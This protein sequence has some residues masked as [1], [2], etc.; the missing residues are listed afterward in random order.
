MLK[1]NKNKVLLS[2]I[3]KNPN[4]NKKN[5]PEIRKYPLMSKKEETF[6]I[7]YNNFNSSIGLNYI[8]SI[9]F[10]KQKPRMAILLTG[11]HYAENFHHWSGKNFDID[12]RQYY[13]NIQDNLYNHFSDRF[14]ID[15]F[16]CTDKSKMF[17][18]L[19]KY[20]Q[21]IEYAICGKDKLTKTKKVL[22][23]LQNHMKDTNKNYDIICIT[24]FDLYFF[25][26]VFNLNLDKL[27]L[28]SRND[29]KNSVDDNFYL[30]P[31]KYL[32]SFIT[33]LYSIEDKDKDYRCMHYLKDRFEKSMNIN[34]IFEDNT[35]GLSK[36]TLFAFNF[37]SRNEY[38]FI[39]NKYMFT[40]NIEYTIDNNILFISDNLI[41]FKTSSEKNE[42][43]WFG[44]II[45]EKGEYKITYNIVTDTDVS[46]NYLF[47]H[48]FIETNFI[49]KENESQ[50]SLNVKT[51]SDD[52]LFVFNFNDY[53]NVN[54]N[55]S[56]LSL[57]KISEVV[58]LMNI[59]EE[60]NLEKI[61]EEVS[62]DEISKEVN[63]TNISE[64]VSLEKR[65]E[66]VNLEKRSEDVSL[67]DISKAVGFKKIS[68]LSKI[69]KIKLRKN[70]ISK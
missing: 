38:S 3:D 17:D 25:K 57:E 7:N 64:E 32:T 36:F 9:K 19:L 35:T 49:K 46:G 47:V 59:S 58:S 37:F 44:F 65:S 51:K 48:S 34:Y 11:L 50:I 29:E 14:E 53:Q 13:R 28:A 22:S 67:D 15:T 2:K 5:I 66:D 69:R 62:L 20:Y 43:S 8:D 27:N 45:K 63:L 41:K 61:S 26:S 24:R 55:V 21:P 30:F 60:E 12:F 68:E 54:V 1:L 33:C 56:N 6:L 52:E 40:D 23:L 10:I 42:N 4:I 39:L 18:E 31:S 70:R 16:I